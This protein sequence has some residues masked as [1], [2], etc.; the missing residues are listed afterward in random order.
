MINKLKKQKIF[1]LQIIQML[2]LLELHVE[3]QIKNYYTYI[4]INLNYISIKKIMGN[5]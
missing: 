5:Q 2:L 4:K 3:I 1:L